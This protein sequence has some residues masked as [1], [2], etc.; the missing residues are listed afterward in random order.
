MSKKIFP[1]LPCS[2]RGRRYY[3]TS[4]TECD[5]TTHT[6]IFLSSWCSATSWVDLAVLW[7]SHLWLTHIF[8]RAIIYFIVWVYMSLTWPL[9]EH[10]AV[11]TG[12]SKARSIK[13]T[14]LNEVVWVWQHVLQP[15]LIKCTWNKYPMCSLF[16][17]VILSPVFDLVTMAKTC[18][19]FVSLLTGQ[20]NNR[21]LEYV[22]L[23]CHSALKSRQIHAWLCYKKAKLKTGGSR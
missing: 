11:F 17:V 1:N 10:L 14:D 7:R 16:W 3:Q 2:T 21:S 22:F 18:F 6:T 15:G 8:L 19:T 9:C 12:G 4:R 20:Y 13:G 5:P 23:S